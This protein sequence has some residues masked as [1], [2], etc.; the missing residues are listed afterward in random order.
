MY[1]LY[2]CCTQVEEM[3]ISAIMPMI[4]VHRLP[5]GQYVCSGHLI[6]LPQ[7][8]LSFATTLPRLPSALDVVVVRKKVPISHTVTF[9]YVELLLSWP[10]SG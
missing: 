2:S 7:D 1:K 9:M 5:Q 6:N 3:L 8:V 4:S 10:W